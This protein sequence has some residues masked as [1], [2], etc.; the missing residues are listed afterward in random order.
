MNN[1]KCVLFDFDGVIA[2]T[3]E[4]NSEYCAKAMLHFGVVMTTEDKKSLVGAHGPSVIQ[5]LLDRAEQP[6]TMD[7]FL[8]I[9]AASGNTYEDGDLKAEPGVILLIEALRAAGVKTAVVSSTRAKLILAGLNRLHMLPLFDIVLCGDMTEK[10]KP[11][12]FPY[13]KAMEMLGVSPEETIVVEDSPIGIHAG[14]S[15]GADV[16]AYTGGTVKQD[17][18]EAPYSASSFDAFFDLIRNNGWV[19]L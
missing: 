15:S 10:H 6:A 5:R 9:R 8:R 14:V 11:D 3:E 19:D 1:K 18:H 7:D 4:S 16:I 13:Q 17:I 12:P 2:D